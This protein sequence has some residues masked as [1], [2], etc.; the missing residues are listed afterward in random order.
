MYYYNLYQHRR[1]RRN[2]ERSCK[3]IA[4]GQS[5]FTPIHWICFILICVS[6][7]ILSLFR[8]YSYY[9]RSNSDGNT[10]MHHFY[11]QSLSSKATH[12]SHSQY[13]NIHSNSNSNSDNNNNIN[14]N[15][16]L[17]MPLSVGQI[18]HSSAQSDQSMSQRVSQSM[19]KLYTNDISSQSN[20]AAILSPQSN[21]NPNPINILESNLLKSAPNGNFHHRSLHRSLRVDHDHETRSE[22]LELEKNKIGDSENINENW[23]KLNSKQELLYGLA[24]GLTILTSDTN[25]WSNE[26][27][28]L[29]HK[30]NGTNKNKKIEENENENEN[31]YLDW[32]CN[33]SENEIINELESKYLK[34]FYMIGVEGTGHHLWKE[35]FRHWTEFRPTLK[36][37]E[38][39]D[40]ANA[41]ANDNM[42][43][44]YF[45]SYDDK[46]PLTTCLHTYVT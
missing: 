14:N 15:N 34:M 7:V 44:I 29:N 19:N 16:R 43:H 33:T 10:I 20:A 8:L 24:K 2:K 31:E 38:T 40:N 9:L 27:F 4:S 6:L 25:T 26:T 37:G 18:A 32:Q 42:S 11:A 45:E 1:A 23:I 30:N 35:L 21:T 3:A 36:R 46:S 41:N 12:H 13:D 39:D 28:D 22:Q 17:M 5:S